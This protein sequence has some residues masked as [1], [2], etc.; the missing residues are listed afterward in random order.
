MRQTPYCGPYILFK[1]S[2]HVNTPGRQSDPEMLNSY[3]FFWDLLMSCRSVAMYRFLPANLNWTS[4][5][6]R[7]G[8]FRKYIWKAPARIKMN[9]CYYGLLTCM[10]IY[11]PYT[12]LR[13]TYRGYGFCINLSLFW[14]K[15]KYFLHRKANWDT[16]LGQ[17]TQL[18]RVN[19]KRNYERVKRCLT[20]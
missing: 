11:V 8:T 4:F 14:T 7:F 17:G 20:K 5:S 10:D 2:C 13:S 18:S 12:N 19:T 16:S 6:G 15:K 1:K 3:S 9:R